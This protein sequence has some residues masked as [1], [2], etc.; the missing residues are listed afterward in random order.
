MDPIF[1]YRNPEAG[2]GAAPTGAPASDPLRGL[3][4]ALQPDISVKGWPAQ[5]G[6]NALAGFTA[7]EDATVVERL[8]ARGATL[9]G[10]TRMSEFGFGLD[11]STAG[12]ALTQQAADVELVMDF[13]GEARMAAARAGVCC[14][15]PSYGTVSRYGLVSL[16]PSMECCSILARDPGH[17]AASLDAVAGDDGR[18][19][20]LP[21]EQAPRP[22]A[23]MPPRG[24]TVGVVA[25]P[26]NLLAAEE[27]EEFR[28]TLTSL[29]QT[30][31]TVRQLSLPE[32]A[33]FSAV[34]RI[35]GSVEASSCLGRYD[36]VR[37]GPRAPGA[38]NWN[39]MYLL[40]RGA[41]F[42]TLVKSFLIQ[43]AFFQ[44]ERYSAFEDACR[45][46]ARLVKGMER[47]LREVD[48]LALPVSG[49]AV[50]DQESGPTTLDGLYQ[51]S[52]FT[53]AANVTG[54]PALSLPA[55]PEAGRPTSLQ[56]VGP[57]LSDNRL[58]AL[59]DLLLTA[60]GGE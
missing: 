19:F 46:R 30:G 16:I 32:F 9:C 60:R 3:S 11:G 52:V 49:G 21:D 56:L 5:A 42:G 1:I 54:Q 37:Y 31:L 33:L 4:F 47:L 7:L 55:A 53:L 14:L 45:I 40:S 50:S 12:Q 38:K 35:V 22:S 23:G 25:E 18:D 44:F 26:A 8:R 6:S 10:Y 48:F 51:E 41:A 20:S 29:E 17:I 58:L 15:K 43:G 59:G 13:A 27:A 39:E 34:H 36:S 57:R 2:A 24:T 28:T